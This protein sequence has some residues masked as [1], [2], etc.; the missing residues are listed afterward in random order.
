MEAEV[1]RVGRKPCILDSDGDGDGW[2]D[3][4]FRGLKWSSYVFCSL[5]FGAIEGRG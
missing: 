1:S 5:L 2:I 3:F 4:D